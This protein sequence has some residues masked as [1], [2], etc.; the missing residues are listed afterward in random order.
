MSVDVTLTRSFNAG[1]AR[2]LFE[3]PRDFL[4]QTRTP[5]SIADV[6]RDHQRIFLLRPAPDVA[7][8]GINV[9]LNWPTL[10]AR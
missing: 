3:L 6:S 5:G 1:A 7:R 4:A 8:Q 2:P 9:V 10:L